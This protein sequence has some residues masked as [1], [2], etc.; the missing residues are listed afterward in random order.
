MLNL[1]KEFLIEGKVGG[2]H[3]LFKLNFS[4]QNVFL[5]SKEKKTKIL[6]VK[7]REESNIYKLLS[8]KKK[9]Y[10]IP[11][12]VSNLSNFLI[13]VSNLIP[14]KKRHQGRAYNIG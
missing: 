9:N 13:V 14:L 11:N 12:L 10:F 7:K 4:I 6:F 8:I 1:R 5:L 2:K 3:C